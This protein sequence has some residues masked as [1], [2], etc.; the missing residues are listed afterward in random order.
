MN[1]HD[2]L[3]YLMGNHFSIYY[4]DKEIITKLYVIETRAEFRPPPSRSIVYSFEVSATRDSSFYSDRDGLRLSTSFYSGAP[5]YHVR[6]GNTRIPIYISHYEVREEPIYHAPPSG[7]LVLPPLER[8]IVMNCYLVSDDFE[9]VKT[10]VVEIEPIMS[11]WEILDI[12]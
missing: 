8:K 6:V 5:E 1:G 2:V 7:D 12:R 10:K 11:R 4:R 3:A 9:E